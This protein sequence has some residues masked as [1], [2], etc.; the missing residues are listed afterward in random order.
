MAINNMN[1]NS[2]LETIL[3]DLKDLLNAKKHKNIV[4]SE[5]N[6]EG[7]IDNNYVE[8]NIDD[9]LPPGEDTDGE[10]EFMM[11]DDGPE[12]HDLFNDNNEEEPDEK[13]KF[14]RD[15]VIS[16]LQIMR[17][18]GYIDCSFKKNSGFEWSYIPPHSYLTLAFGDEYNPNK[19]FYMVLDNKFEINENALKDSDII[20]NLIQ[21]FKE[22]Y[23]RCSKVLQ[24]IRNIY[25]IVY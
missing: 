6:E 9:V 11:K 10:D 15:V 1:N 2:D 25:P 16:I 24:E 8:S 13:K 20:S 22:E 19:S 4:L 17:E 14:D 5:G 21:S 7:N 18:N 3:D 12:D 23:D